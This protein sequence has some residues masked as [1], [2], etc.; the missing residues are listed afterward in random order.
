[1]GNTRFYDGNPLSGIIEQKQQQVSSFCIDFYP[2][3]LLVSKFLNP[4]SVIPRESS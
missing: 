2:L 1:M 4:S 3:T